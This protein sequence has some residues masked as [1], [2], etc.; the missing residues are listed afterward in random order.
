[1]CRSFRTENTARRVTFSFSKTVRVPLH[2]AER[3]FLLFLGE[4]TDLGDV[5]GQNPERDQ[6]S[7]D[8]DY[9]FNQEDPLPSSQT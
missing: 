3:V 7:S 1:M 9:T 5:V 8:G 6:A 4:E 2:P